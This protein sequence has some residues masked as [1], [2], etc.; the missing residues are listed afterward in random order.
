MCSSPEVASS[1]V[2]NEEMRRIWLWQQFAAHVTPTVQ[3]VVEFAKRVPG[4]FSS[5]IIFFKLFWYLR[6][7]ENNFLFPGFCNLSQDDQLILIKIGFFELWLG[8]VA[9]LTSDT[10]LTFY[11]GTFITK[12]QME[13]MYDVSTSFV[14]S[15]KQKLQK[16][17]TTK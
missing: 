6:A 10:T 2:E 11:D 12:Q 16:K 8:Q 3:R 5:V 17:A 7:N 15:E 13:T 1:T 14:L 4:T 9:R